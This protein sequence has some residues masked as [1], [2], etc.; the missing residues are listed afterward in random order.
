MNFFGFKK[1]NSRSN[2]PFLIQEGKFEK[3]DGRY[4]ETWSDDF[5]IGKD[6]SKGSLGRSFDFKRLRF[7]NIFLGL[8]LAIILGRAGWLQIAKGSYYYQMAEGNRVRIERLPANRGVVYDRNYLPLVRNVANF[9]LYV[10]P[11]DLPADAKETEGLAARIGEILNVKK[12]DVLNI[13]N[14]VKRRSYEAY[15][16]LFI[17]DNI[18]YEMAIKLDLLASG[19][20][21]VFL[22]S[23]TRREY[24]IYCNSMSHVLGYTGKI[25][26]DELKKYGPEY[27]PIDYVGKNGVEYFWENQ[28]RGK[29]G[30]NKLKSTPWERKK[31]FW[32]KKKGRT[33]TIWSWPSI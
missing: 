13:I 4:R 30:K 8:A 1:F 5:L 25:S 9:M 12:E 18:P 22:S 2:E 27:L 24:N 11:S 15:Q 32:E 6:K 10:I 3:L 23:K 26:P 21:G 7:F 31:R 33:G 28:L 16:P 14:S 19:E 20:K 17:A 29:D